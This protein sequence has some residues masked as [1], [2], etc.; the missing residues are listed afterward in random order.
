MLLNQLS[1]CLQ[2]NNEVELYWRYSFYDSVGE[3]YLPKKLGDRS[4]VLGRLKQDG[5][6]TKYKYNN[7]ANFSLIILPNRLVGQINEIL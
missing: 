3:T 5:N 2:Q 4:D 1:S 6:C 7:L